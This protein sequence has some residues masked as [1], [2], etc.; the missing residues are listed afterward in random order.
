M[1][2]AD[3]G[4]DKAAI[5]ARRVESLHDAEAQ[6][7]AAASN[8]NEPAHTCPDC[9]RPVSGPGRRCYGCNR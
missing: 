7:N 9:D 1:N 5:L 3:S 8:V 6:S 4:I 2:N